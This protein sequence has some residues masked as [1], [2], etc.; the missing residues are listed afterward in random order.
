MRII[1]PDNNSTLDLI[2]T[3]FKFLEHDFAFELIRVETNKKE[4]RANNFLIYL[5]VDSCKQ[6]EICA[7]ES[8]FHCE[9]RRIVFNQ[10]VKY[11]DKYN[12]IGFE[13]LAILESN[14]KYEHLDYFAG[15]K[16][17]LKRVLKNTA[18]LFYRYADFFKTNKWFDTVR[19][20]E[21]KNIDFIGKFGKTVQRQELSYFEKLK[22]KCNKLLYE[23]GYDLVLDSRELSPFNIDSMTNKLIYQKQNIEIII[24]QIDWRDLNNIYRVT[25]QNRELFEIDISSLEID[26]AVEMTLGKLKEEI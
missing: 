5:N 7:D 13:D 17:G 20:E 26:D 2:M 1:Y 18:N 21:I 15:G 14:N 24:K 4:F 25:K 9:I 12:C 16:N 23:N 11:N 3:T 19:I 10:P 6:V 22:E 8:W